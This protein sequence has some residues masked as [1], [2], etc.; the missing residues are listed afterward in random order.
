[1]KAGELAQGVDGEVAGVLLVVEEPVVVGA[2]EGLAAY[3]VG[4]P[5]EQDKPGGSVGGLGRRRAA[6]DQAVV[7]GADDVGVE[8]ETAADRWQGV[9]VLVT[10]CVA[11]GGA[12][13]P[14]SLHEAAA[15]DLIGAERAKVATSVRAL[16][17]LGWLPVHGSCLELPL[18]AEP[19]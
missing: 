18:E 5:A 10:E 3:S 8:T 15:P 1:V 9:D 17:A 12:G 6:G 7:V 13:S 16:A 2:G 14:G 11:E 19:V 4:C